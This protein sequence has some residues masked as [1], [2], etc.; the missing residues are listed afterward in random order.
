M[1]TAIRRARPAPG[2]TDGARAGA[3]PPGAPDVTG[4]AADHAV[5]VLY[6]SHYAALV[7]EAALLVG[8]V[9]TAEDVVQDCFIA[10]HRAWWR[11]RDASTA[12]FY[13]RRSVINKSR[14]V[15]RRRAVAGRHPVLPEPA[16][17]SAEDSA[18]AVVQLSSVRAALRA[19]PVRQREVLVLRYYADLSE[20]QI[21]AVLGISKGSVKVHAARARNALRAALAPSGLFS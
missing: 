10:L 8:D 14:S 15:L 16:L 12:V 20:T 4:Q 9:A 21:A 7:R 17:P 13:L 19:L 11:V 2:R 1:A 6:Q 3:A 5:T 18:L